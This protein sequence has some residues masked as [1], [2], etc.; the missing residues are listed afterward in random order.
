MGLVCV[1]STVGSG[2]GW[3]RG[4]AGAGLG[5]LLPLLALLDSEALSSSTRARR[6]LWPPRGCADGRADVWA[7]HAGAPV[8]ADGVARA[9]PPLR[10]TAQTHG[11]AFFSR[12]LRLSFRI[13]K[14]PQMVHANTCQ[15]ISTTYRFQGSKDLPLRVSRMVDKFSPSPSVS[16]ERTE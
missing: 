7:A 11:A 4:C 8:G 5:L 15:I 14:L 9:C 13:L 10:F 2:V 6:I 12:S 1:W 16:S 3:V